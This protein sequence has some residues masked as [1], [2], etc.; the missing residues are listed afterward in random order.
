MRFLV[1]GS[2]AWARQSAVLKL[3]FTR[4]KLSFS[5][6]TSVECI[7]PLFQTVAETVH[8]VPAKITGTIPT[9][10][11][12]SLLRNGPG[13]FEFGN[14]KY[15]HWF[16]GMA[17][18]HNFKIENGSVTYMS[19]FL[20]SDSYTTNKSENRIVISEFGTLAMPDPCKSVFERFMS[21]F[22]LTSTDNCSVNYVQYKGDYYVSTETNF[23][24]R[25]DPK[26][27]E[28]LEK[29]D[30]S[31]FIAVNGATAHP[32]YDPDGTAYNMG[33][34]YGKSGTRYNIIRVPA[35]KSN[36]A[37]TLEGAQVVCSIEPEDKMKPSYYHSFAMTENYVV[38][39]ELPLKLNIMKIL[40][41]QI[42]GKAFSD[43]MSWEPQLNTMFHVV[44][45]HTGER[46][47]V[48]FYTEPFMNFHQINAYE[49]QGCIVLD[50]CGQDD[51]T[52]VKLFELQNLRKSGQALDELYKQVSKAYPRR[53]VLPLG[54]DSMKEDVDL[55][56]LKYTSA[57]A[58]KQADGKVWCTHESLHDHTLDICGLEFPQINYSK[59]NTK[60][61]RFIYGCG[62]QHLVGDS[63]IKLDVETKKAKVWKEKGFYPSEPIFVPYPESTEEDDGVLLSAV[64]TPHQDKNI[65]LLILDA[66]EFTEI[67]RAEVPVQIPYGFHGIF[68]PQRS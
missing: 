16:D 2:P 11:N 1:N 13:R 60:K 64:L 24:R 31:Q 58:V 9:W 52:A 43:S 27:L 7:A 61:Y 66:K 36:S 54:T 47:S 28:T 68:V 67:G 32:H 55:N 4:A 33:N 42:K 57:T 23:I 34:S 59:Y 35:Q 48:T 63:L 3:L 25:V 20:Q 21:K 6:Q 40:T 17:L 22:K 30:W 14:D 29:V 65:F 50:L 56:P 44:N 18:M 51:G 37:E 39:L 26:D 41:S 46:H 12:G 15:R 49:D 8:P 62:F 19:K 53:F 5:T 10:V 38:F 45:K